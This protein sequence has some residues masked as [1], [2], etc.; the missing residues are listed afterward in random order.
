MRTLLV[1][2]DGSGSARDAT[3]WSVAAAQELG[4]D[5]VLAC[6]VPDAE[7]PPPRTSKRR[8]PASGRLGHRHEGAAAYGRPCRRPPGTR[9]STSRAKWKPTWSSWVEEIAVGSRRCTSGSVSHGS[10]TSA[11]L[12]LCV[13][14]PEKAGFDVRRIVVGLDGSETST[15]AEAWAAGARAIRWRE[16]DR[17]VRVASPGTPGTAGG[18]QRARTGRGRALCGHVG[19]VRAVR[20]PIEV[21]R[22]GGRDP[23]RRCCESSR[24]GTR[25]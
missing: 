15:S 17:R 13:V 12:P 19:E 6:I 18:G 16:P 7:S 1:G 5:V 2:V 11:A 22:A 25:R 24:S 21:H 10:R 4:L 20:V 23:P 14:P 3:D 8:S 9:W